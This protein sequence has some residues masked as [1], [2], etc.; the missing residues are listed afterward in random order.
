MVW[1]F[2]RK[3]QFL[4]SF[5]RKLCGKC[6]FSKNFHT[7][8]LG[9]ITVIYGLWKFDSLC[10][11]SGFFVE[12]TGCK[13]AEY[14]GFP[15]RKKLSQRGGSFK[16]ENIAMFTDVHYLNLPWD[17]KHALI[18]YVS[19]YSIFNLKTKFFI[20]L[21]LFIDKLLFSSL[22]FTRLPKSSSMNQWLSKF[23]TC[24]TFC[25][26]LYRTYF[27]FDFYSYNIIL[28]FLLAPQHEIIIV[29]V[30]SLYI[31]LNSFKNIY[32]LKGIRREARTS[33]NI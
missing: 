30:V 4:Q 2:S 17:Q 20:F 21:H 28:S 27:D 26:K 9:E 22:S 15:E 25:R 33:V 3:S 24:F 1:K 19:F 31:Y 23:S 29:K 7:R 32:S 16:K 18:P 12:S 14:V 10:R 5:G 6:A 13:Y 11:A 8:K